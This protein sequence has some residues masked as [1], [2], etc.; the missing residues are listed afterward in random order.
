MST[1]LP[2]HTYLD[3]RNI[4]YEIRIFSDTTEKGAAN[5]AK[6]LGFRERQMI[7]TLLFETD[8]GDHALVMVGADQNAVSGLLKKALGSRNISLARPEV[9]QQVTGYVIGSIPPFHWQPE[10][11]CSLLDESLMSES[12]LGVGAGKWGNEILIEP[13]HLVNASNA[14][15]VNLTQK[16]ES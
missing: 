13:K 16:P 14:K 8:R 11:F 2:A 9:V 3:Q 6:V 15:V 5:V 1:K 12:I 10:G 4:P 7:K